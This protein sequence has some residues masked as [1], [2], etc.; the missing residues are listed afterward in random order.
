MI[1]PI[2][3]WNILLIFAAAMNQDIFL[4]LRNYIRGQDWAYF[5]DTWPNGGMYAHLNSYWICQFAQCHTPKIAQGTTN[6]YFHYSC[7]LEHV[8]VPDSVRQICASWNG[9]AFLRSFERLK[10]LQTLRLLNGAGNTGPLT[11]LWS[12]WSLPRCLI[13]L[14]LSIFNEPVVGVREWASLIH[15][16]SLVLGGRF[17][18]PVVGFVL[19]PNLRTLRMAGD[20]DQPVIG[21]ALPPCLKVLEMVNCNWTNRF[22]IPSGTS[23]GLGWKLPESLRSLRLPEAFDQ[24]VVSVDTRSYWTLPGSLRKLI[25][26]WRFNQPVLGWKLPDSLTKINLGRNFNQSLDGWNVPKNMVEFRVWGDFDQPL[27]S[28]KLPDGLSKLGLLGRFNQDIRALSLP[29]NL[30]HLEL[31]YDWDQPVL[32]WKLPESLRY[33]HFSGMN[34]PVLHHGDKLIGWRLPENLETLVLTKFN[35]PVVG[36]DLPEKLQELCLL[37]FQDHPVIG[38]KL[39]QSLTRLTLGYSFN[40]PVIEVDPTGKVVGWELPDSVVRLDLGQSFNQPIIVRGVDGQHMCWKLPESLSVLELPPRFNQPV[41]AVSSEGFYGCWRLPMELKILRF[42][43]D[44][45]QPLCFAPGESFYFPDSLLEL[46]FGMMFNQ[47]VINLYLPPHLEN[48]F[49]GR[50]FVKPVELHDPDRYLVLPM[51]MKKVRFHRDSGITWTKW[52]GPAGCEAHWDT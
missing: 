33:L 37:G 41:C 35:H 43:T 44:F 52:P 30:T 21:W 7:Q 13:A 14:E 34:Q 49:F 25:F 26:G 28:L 31:G 10:K 47:D 50:G 46:K 3:C 36:W 45:N 12:D 18:Q 6:V 20:F 40:Q 16:R 27:N 29:R 2:P 8:D 9:S 17:N 19:P 1:V 5:T 42:G 15:L 48:L 22:F 38:W 4:K 11:G 39:P 24:P 32:A 23:M 51:S